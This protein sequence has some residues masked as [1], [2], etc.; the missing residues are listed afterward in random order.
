MEMPFSKEDFFRIFESYNNGVWPFQILLYVLAII[1]VLLVFWKTKS[2]AFIIICILSVFWLWMGAV[3]HILFF[4]LINPAA[5]V[6]GVLFIAE[7]MLLFYSAISLNLEFNIRPAASAYAAVILILFA[8]AI[9]PLLGYYLGHRYP[10]SPTFGLP[11]PTTIFTL[12]IFLL[13]TGRIPLSLV[14]IPLLWA[15]IGSTAALKLDVYED[16]G[17]LISAVVFLFFF[18]KKRKALPAVMPN[19]STA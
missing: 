13:I 6:F 11:C 9:Y 17:L 18:L 16:T 7:A 14:I 4:S 10:Y 15:V 1:A 2:S 8:L 3:Y 12:A 19:N 5:Y